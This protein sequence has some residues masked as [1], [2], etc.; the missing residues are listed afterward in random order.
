MAFQATIN[1]IAPSDDG[2]GG[3]QFLVGVTFSD[4]VTNWSTTKTYSFPPAT[5]QA[6]AQAQI[7]ADGNLYKSKLATLSNLTAKV[8]TVITI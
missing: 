4:S 7:T 6:A 3:I 2:Q 8:G 1:T 5:T